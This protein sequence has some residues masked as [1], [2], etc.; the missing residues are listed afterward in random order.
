M[1]G[2]PIATAALVTATALML[3]FTEPAWAERVL[4]RRVSQLEKDK[5]VRMFEQSYPAL[6]AANVIYKQCG[7]ELAIADEQRKYLSEKFSSVSR[8]YMIAYKDAYVNYAQASPPQK[9]VDDIAKSIAQ[10]QQKAVNN[11]ALILR[12]K[13]CS[14]S[15]LK[16]IVKYVESLRQKDIAE[17]NK[18]TVAPALPY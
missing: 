10:K 8:S 17:Q 1:F 16:P 11:V 12:Q 9:L 4:I 18:P 3:L 6:S 7:A 5:G 2:M 15:R 13:G 14:D